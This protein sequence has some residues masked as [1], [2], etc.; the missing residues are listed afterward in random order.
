MA[1]STLTVVVLRQRVTDT[2]GWCDPCALPSVTTV[3]SL[4]YFG[5]P[6]LHDCRMDYVVAR[7]CDSCGRMEYVD[8]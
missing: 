6:P 1:V 5:P 3:E 8:G 2:G 7:G 4:I